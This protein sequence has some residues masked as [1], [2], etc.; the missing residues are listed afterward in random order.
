MNREFSLVR[1]PNQL[2]L[3][4][5][6]SPDLDHAGNFCAKSIKFLISRTDPFTS[7]SFFDKYMSISYDI[8]GPRDRGTDIL[9]RYSSS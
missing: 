6:G 3:V 2:K 8:Q 7:L 1:A 4:I 9:T 5:N